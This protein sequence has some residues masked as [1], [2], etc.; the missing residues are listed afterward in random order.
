MTNRTKFIENVIF[1]ASLLSTPLDILPEELHNIK[2]LIN[3]D[4]Y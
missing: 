4:K 2:W 3:I 1:M